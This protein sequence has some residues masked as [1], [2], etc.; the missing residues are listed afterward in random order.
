[1]VKRSLVLDGSSSHENKLPAWPQISLAFCFLFIFQTQPPAWS[2]EAENIRF[3]P[4]LVLFKEK[5]DFPLLSLLWDGCGF[6]RQ[7]SE[8]CVRLRFSFWV[9]LE[10]E[11]K[12][13][14]CSGLLQWRSVSACMDALYGPGERL[15]VR[16]TMA[17]ATTVP[18]L[19]LFQLGECKS[20]GLNC[21]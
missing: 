16:I 13:E 7:T 5:A 9:W 1:M 4:S 18:V 6:Q 19:G 11:C 15:A 20:P 8:W 2:F 21:E 14:L 10:E 3:L 12:A 17:M